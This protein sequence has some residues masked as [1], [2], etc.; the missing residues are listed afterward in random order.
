MGTGLHRNLQS[1]QL[2][3]DAAASTS[4]QDAASIGDP[5]G[6][7][8]YESYVPEDGSLPAGSA[9]LVNPLQQT[10]TTYINALR[11]INKGADVAKKTAWD[12]GS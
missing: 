9:P 1:L 3:S 4:G 10:H 8:S 12:V 6:S 7:L 11:S 2:D 5:V